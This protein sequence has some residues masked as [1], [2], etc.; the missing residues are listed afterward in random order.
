[1]TAFLGQLAVAD[2]VLRPVDHWVWLAQ[3]G[4]PHG[5]P[6]GQN[7]AFEGEAVAVG[8]YPGD[9]ADRPDVS[10]ADDDGEAL[11]AGLLGVD[12]PHSPP[13]LPRLGLGHP[14]KSP[15]NERPRGRPAQSRS[16]QASTG[17]P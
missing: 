1:R 14:G 8:A 17:S 9:L 16:C 2:R 3:P 6:R 15:T 10:F 4:I 12:P 7:G 11:P 13:G 5:V